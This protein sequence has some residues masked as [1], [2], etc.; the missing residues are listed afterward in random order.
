MEGR[1]MPRVNLIKV[2]PVD[3]EA[4]I[5]RSPGVLIRENERWSVIDPANNNDLIKGMTPA[6]RDRLIRHGL[7]EIVE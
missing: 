4:L 7:M 1:V 2:I 5:M 3:G 6:F